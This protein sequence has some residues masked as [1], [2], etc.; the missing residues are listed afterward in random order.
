MDI[1]CLVYVLILGQY[2]QHVFPEQ[3]PFRLGHTLHGVTIIKSF[4]SVSVKQCQ[5]LCQARERCKSIKYDRLL[6]LC[7]LCSS[8]S[9]TEGVNVVHKAR[10][11]YGEKR[12]WHKVKLYIKKD[13]IMFIISIF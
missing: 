10:T 2:I 12:H 1:S 3:L 6:L 9:S 8:D 7:H 11:I 5:R 13:H 4:E